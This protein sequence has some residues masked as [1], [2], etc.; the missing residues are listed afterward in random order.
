VWVGSTTGGVRSVD[1]LT[2][3]PAGRD[4]PPSAASFGPRTASA[5]DF[6]EPGATARPRPAFGRGGKSR[7]TGRLKWTHE[8]KW[9]TWLEPSV[10]VLVSMEIGLREVVP[11]EGPLEV[12]R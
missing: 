3:R 12:K 8:R 5:A 6:V 10:H 7:S 11:G 1:Q 4:V 9:L 2:A